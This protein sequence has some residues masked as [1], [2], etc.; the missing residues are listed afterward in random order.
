[1]RCGAPVIASDN[2]SLPEVVGDAGILVDA[3]KP[4]E[5]S[6]ALQSVLSDQVLQAAMI[7]KGIKRSEQFTWEK[8]GRATLNVLTSVVANTQWQLQNLTVA[9]REKL[10]TT[11]S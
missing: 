3:E 10:I 4:V 11:K 7:E 2:S 6:Q 9:P 8:T 1:M 5:I